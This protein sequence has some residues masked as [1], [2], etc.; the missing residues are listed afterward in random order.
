[1]SEIYYKKRVIEYDNDEMNQVL[2]QDKKLK[3]SWDNYK[4]EIQPI[5]STLCNE[6]ETT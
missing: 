6:N 5:Y 4:Y 1:M 3:S 2:N